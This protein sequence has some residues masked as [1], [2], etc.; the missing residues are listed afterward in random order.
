[1]VCAILLMAGFLTYGVGLNNPYQGDDLAQIVDSVP[2]HSLSHLGLLFEGS[3]F[4]EGHGLQPLSGT[5]Y[6]PLMTTAFA[7]V[8]NL[9]G[10][11]SLYE[12]LVQLVFGIGASLLV[13]LFFS[14][15]FNRIVALICALFFL[16]HPINVQVLLAIPSMQ[17]V[18]YFFFGMLA[19]WLLVRFSGRR[20]IPV[21][22]TSLFLALLAKE[23]A[24]LFLLMAVVYLFWWSRERLWWFLGSMIVPLALFIGLRIHAV[25]LFTNPAA[26]PIDS[27]SLMG[28]LINTPEIILF[29]TSKIVFPWRLASAYYWVHSGVTLR[30]FVVP[31]IMDLSIAAGL[32]WFGLWLK[33]QGDKARLYTYLF[34]VIWLLSGLALLLQVIPLDMTVSTAWFYFP[35]VGVLGIGAM[36]VQAIGAH[37]SISN[38]VMIGVVVV[39]LLMCGV[40]TALRAH[41]YRSQQAIDQVDIADQS[42]NYAAYFQQSNIELRAGDLPMAKSDAVKSI[43]IYPSFSNYNS[44]GQISG[45]L[46]NYAEAKAAYENAIQ[47]GGSYSTPYENLSQLMLIYGNPTTNQQFIESSVNRF[48]EDPTLWLYL[49]IF[50]QKYGNNQVARM[51]IA[52]SAQYGTVPPLLYNTIEAND[53]VS[54][55]LTDLNTSVK[56]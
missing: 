8:Y 15:S 19:I 33:K 21:A 46:G 3:T 12:H 35:M 47:Y 45:K 5:Y 43:N 40:R 56:L 54:I 34:F 18:L 7:L 55:N 49:A 29:Y 51:A 14:Y 16:V 41:D 37:V 9:L 32:V 38:N 44:L 27:L 50:E 24:V 20:I 11:K 36:A 2:V 6:R 52:K 1:V 25:G 42:S 30:Y 4:Y 17:D 26:G 10:A 13:Y 39:L 53:H 31:V 22:V 28:R 23:T 48:P